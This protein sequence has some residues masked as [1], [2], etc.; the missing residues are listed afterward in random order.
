MSSP[1]IADSFF[2]SRVATVALLV[3]ALVSALILW[4]AYRVEHQRTRREVQAELGN[5]VAGLAGKIDTAVEARRKSLRFLADTP[6]VQGMVRALAND[7]FDALDQSTLAAWE[8]RLKRIFTAYLATNPD[9][10]HV[11]LIGVADGGRELVRLDRR[12]E[13]I[14]VI[15]PEELQRKGDRDYFVEAAQRRPGDVY[16]S[17]VTLNQEHGKVQVPHLPTTRLAVPIS[18]TQGGVFGIVIINVNFTGFLQLAAA[19]APPGA[20]IY[21]TNADGD[22][23]VHP[24]AAKTFGF[25]LGQRYR[26]DAEFQ[27]LPGAAGDDVLLQFSSALGLMHG[28]SR[29][30]VRDP[31][32]PQRQLRYVALKPD[33]L[34]R[35]EI[36]RTMLQTLGILIGVALLLLLL[37]YLYWLSQQREAQAR[38]QRLRLA[39]I[40]DHSNDAIVGLSLRGIVESW[41]MAA[42]RMFGH[43][44]SSAIGQRIDTLLSG[45]GTVCR[46][47]DELPR[48]ASGGTVPSFDAQRHHRDGHAIDVA[49]TVSPVRADSGEVVGAAA[50][51]RDIREQKLAELRILRLNSDLEQQVLDRTA[52]L[53][54]ASALQAAI[55]NNA[56]Y[57]I[58][59]TDP[60]GLITLFNPAAEKQ[61]GY[62]AREMVGHQTPALIHDPEEVLTRAEVL[63]RELDA[64]VEP[65]FEV[66]VV[67]ARQQPADEHEWTYIRKDGSRYPVR[68]NV[69]ALRAADGSITGYLGITIDQTETRRREQALSEARALAESASQAKSQ[70]LANMSH[71]IRTPMNAILG[72]LQLLRRTP[73]NFGQADYATKAETA[74]RTLLTIL[75]DILD[76]SKIEA[77][78][79]ELDPVP[80]L[81]DTLLR[82]L[83]VI[84]SASIGSKEVEVLFDIDPKIPHYVVA[85]AL[86]LQQ[87]LLNLAGNAVKFTQ[88]G[89][90]I[91]GARLASQTADQIEIAFSVRD[92][93]IGMTPAQLERI[94][95]SFEQAEASVTRRF[96]GTGLG[97]AI[98][99]RLVQMMGGDIRVESEPGRGSCFRF[100]V[101]LSTADATTIALAS[102]ERDVQ[103]HDLRVLVV[104]DNPSARE[105]IAAI[106]SSFGWQVETVASGAEALQKLA[107][108]DTEAAS[109]DVVFVDWRMPEMDGWEVSRQLRL[110]TTV[111]KPPLI[112]MATAHGR[113]ALAQ[114]LESEISVIVHQA[115]G[116]ARQ[117]AHHGL[118]AVRRRRRCPRRARCALAPRSV[119]HD[120]H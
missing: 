60:E 9:V 50:L 77:G 41:N 36:L 56:G 49:V 33:R 97:L 55:L 113:E 17:N 4:L 57:A 87:V 76:L 92:T 116:H 24:D 25:D 65:G 27:S 38:G 91:L 35:R 37:L 103:L 84:L 110:R 68:L 19:A 21:V 118:D 74:A 26:F 98:S 101:L 63:S 95:E 117:Q 18:D 40:V 99:R 23:L 16:V 62:S 46:E 30:V 67:K 6:P 28:V 111:G 94:F 58:I 8:G 83:G 64:R 32:A 100:N 11:R 69:S 109:Y 44:A 89:E 51:L 53:E 102:S 29:T 79:L 80:F 13:Q 66:F 82:D 85:D 112:V 52:K 47:F 61:L 1:K 96:G 45:P 86:R 15:P 22:Y 104:D 3:I 34:L 105:I 2:K 119:S 31:A 106:A 42:E 7:G 114:R 39:A 73:L 108:A 93:G 107:P 72:M 78:K 90:V 10:F 43:P 54:A 59:A 81:L 88:Q 12:E 14:V 20:A 71:E 120:G 48:I 70:F 5:V 115:V 75:N